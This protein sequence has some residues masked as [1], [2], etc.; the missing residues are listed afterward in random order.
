M[1]VSFSVS[2]SR[3]VYFREFSHFIV[4]LYHH[5]LAIITRIKER[6]LLHQWR[7]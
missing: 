5:Y 4:P 1:L 7:D 2:G 6:K 3:F